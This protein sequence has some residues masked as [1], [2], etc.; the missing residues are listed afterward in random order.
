VGGRGQKEDF[1][2]LG[3]EGGQK[4]GGV[5]GAVRSGSAR[6]DMWTVERDRDEILG[7][8]GHLDWKTPEGWHQTCLV[9]MCGKTSGDCT[10][11]RQR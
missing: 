1:K 10:N 11:L 5:G 4:V 8:K 9:R 2:N 6:F 3:R 7:G